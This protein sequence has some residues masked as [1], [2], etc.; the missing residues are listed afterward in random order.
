MTLTGN[1]E[2]QHLACRTLAI[3]DIHGCSIA[4]YALLEAIAPERGDTIVLLGDLIDRGPSSNRVIGA[5]IGL[6]AH[7][8][9]VCILG[10][11]EELMLNAIKDNH[12]L[13]RWL[14][15]GGAETMKSYGWTGVLDKSL[16][17]WF[18]SEHIAFLNTCVPYYETRDHILTHAGYVADM[19]MPDQPALA[20]R[21]RTVEANANEPH[22]SGKT[23][24]VGH[25]A[26]RSGRIRDYGHVKCIDTNCVHGGWLTGM[27]VS[28]GTLWQS[29]Q[30]G[31]TRR[32]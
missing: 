27:D 12:A 16:E 2:F 3:G 20:L 10:D 1:W 24:I 4:F 22:V 19:A 11:H 14:R 30:Q 21:W 23:V 7:C 8:N 13:P 25:S 18:P 32:E 28:A 15:N 26:Q 5:A 29:N 31:Q 9:V 17:T 6:T